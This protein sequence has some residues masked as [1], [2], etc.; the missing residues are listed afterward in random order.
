MARYFS[1]QAMINKWFG[2]SPTSSQER[3]ET[4]YR[5]TPE[6]QP[7]P[8]EDVRSEAGSMRVEDSGA[9]PQQVEGPDGP[10]RGGTTSLGT[11]KPGH[12][13]TSG[14]GN[15]GLLGGK[16]PSD[17]SGIADTRNG[18]SRCSR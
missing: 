9:L 12:F 2:R 3:F 13:N 14:P 16:I 5:E 1:P 17:G 4:R 6:R 15:G 10:P 11:S 7:M 18:S 8:A